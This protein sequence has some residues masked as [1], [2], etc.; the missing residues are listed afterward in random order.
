M[1][2]L[3]PEGSKVDMA[4]TALL[5]LVG[6]GFWLLES[7]KWLFGFTS[8]I[9]QLGAKASFYGLPEWHLNFEVYYRWAVGMNSFCTQ[10]HP[11]SRIFLSSSG[12]SLLK[13]LIRAWCPVDLT[14]FPWDIE[15]LGLRKKC[16]PQVDIWQET[17]MQIFP[18]C[19]FQILIGLS[20]LPQRIDS[21]VSLSLS[22]LSTTE[23]VDRQ[24]VVDSEYHA[25]LCRSVH[26]MI[27]RWTPFCQEVQQDSN[28][29]FYFSPKDLWWRIDGGKILLIY[30]IGIRHRR[31]GTCP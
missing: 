5:I 18:N 27:G 19:E 30:I 28:K 22:S 11:V 12:S 7:N 2:P 23:V 17:L 14:W 4:I 1:T 26:S 6:P 24:A 20:S 8:S 16:L 29:R 3:G 31:C 25:A 10:L 21:A 15:C 13:G 9:P